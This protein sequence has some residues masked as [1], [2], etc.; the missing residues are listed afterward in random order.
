[1]MFLQVLLQHWKI[2][3]IKEKKEDKRVKSIVEAISCSSKKEDN[4][5]PSEEDATILNP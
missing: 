4:V 3:Q 2:F 5:G 1:M